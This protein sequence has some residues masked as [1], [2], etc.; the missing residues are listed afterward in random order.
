MFTD[1]PVYVGFH[2]YPDLEPQSTWSNKAQTSYGRPTLRL[3][4][5]LALIHH[6]CCTAVGWLTHSAFKLIHCVAL[7]ARTQVKPTNCRGT[8]TIR[9]LVGWLVTRLIWM[10]MQSLCP[11]LLHQPQIPSLNTD[12]EI[13]H[14][15]MHHIKQIHIRRIIE[16]QNFQ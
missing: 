6:L 8:V 3:V 9:W 13:L 14:D 2:I 12:V 15:M 16:L 10:T 4:S 5:W 7:V 1:S 11:Q